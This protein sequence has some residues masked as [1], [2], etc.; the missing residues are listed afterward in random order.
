MKQRV[1]Y[2]FYIE[3]LSVASISNKL[4]ITNHKVKTIINDFSKPSPKDKFI[5]VPSKMNSL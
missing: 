3:H 2:M 5:I 4:L 1:L